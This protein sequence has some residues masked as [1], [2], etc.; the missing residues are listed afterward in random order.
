MRKSSI[1]TL[2]AVACPAVAYALTLQPQELV[3][4][5]DGPPVRRYFFQDEGKRLLFR[6]D[7][8]MSVSGS[9]SQAVFRFSDIRSAAMRLSKSGMTPQVPF[10]EKN[11]EQYR[12]VARGYISRQATDAQITEETPGAIPING[13]LN[14]QIVFSY[15]ILGVPFRQSVTFINYNST[16]QLVFDVM[17][18]EADYEKTYDR[19]YRVLNSLS[20][21]V[22]NAETGPT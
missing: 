20:D 14:H 13:W 4:K 21:Y 6:I 2:C 11:L 19:S 9:A 16:E 5:N 1:I 10:D 12:A 18:S 22:P 3:V 8:K 15:K 17:S 7:G